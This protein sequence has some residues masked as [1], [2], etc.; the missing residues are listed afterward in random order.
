M[1]FALT[2]EQRALG[3]TVRDYL[4]DRFD[5]TAVRAVFEDTGGDGHPAELWKTAG[6][7]GWLAVL[8]PPEHDGLGLGLVDA[9]VVA[10]AFGVGV[11]PG[12]WLPTVLAGEAVRLAGSPEQ[13]RALLPRIATGDLVATVA[14][15]GP[16]G[17][18]DPTGV[19][20]TADAAGRLTGTALPVE[21]AEVART[22]VVAAT[23]TSGQT[24][25]Y[26]VDPRSPGVTVD[27][28]DS[29]D[30]TVR[31]A[32][33]ALDGAD[34]RRL[35]GSSAAVLTEL[36][37]RAAVLTAA[38]LVGLARQAL[39]R[40]VAYDRDRVQ[41]GRPVGSFQALKHHLA[42]LHVAVTMAEHA[43]LYAA[44]ALDVGLADRRL[45]AAVAKSKAGDA[46]REVTGTMIQYHGGIGY[47]WEHE[48]HF[49]YKRAKREIYS[50]GDP[51]HHR[52]RIA[53]LTLGTP[54]APA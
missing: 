46:A 19:R 2:E 48:A 54:S 21:Y 43:V 23:E 45:A 20:V 34:A 49:F 29:Y 11:V 51:D 10:R 8:V 38:D 30:G 7:Q 26:L 1:Y 50:Y 22:V 53:A 12:P 39:G 36:L 27:G 14:L 42:D 40:T 17:R 37:D 13:R 25:L 4:A 47:T 5:L 28:L 52:E 44:H 24:G 18:Y 31:T 16:A 15:R 32:S 35:P 9:Q 41:F 3:D 6:E 33:L